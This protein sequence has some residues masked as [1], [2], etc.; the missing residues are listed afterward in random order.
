MS[1]SA[2]VCSTTAAGRVAVDD[3]TRPGVQD[4][5]SRP[6]NFSY[7]RLS[8]P[9]PSS[10]VDC[11]TP[12]SAGP[13]SRDVVDVGILLPD[14]VGDT[15]STATTPSQVRTEQSCGTSGPRR[16]EQVVTPDQTAQR[17]N[18]HGDVSA[19]ELFYVELD[20]TNDGFRESSVCI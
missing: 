16:T 6:R 11:G 7:R 9:S 4:T 18:T 10:S 1:H 13:P 2:E 3:S 19:T 15:S 12:R 8:T 5:F 20:Q 17:K 14:A